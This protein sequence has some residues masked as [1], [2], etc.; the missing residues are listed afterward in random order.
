MSASERPNLT[1]GGMRTGQQSS[2]GPGVP[3]LI[4]I[5]YWCSSGCKAA[6]PG[7]R[8]G[9]TYASAPFRPTNSKP[10]SELPGT[11]AL[12]QLLRVLGADLSSSK[13]PGCDG[14]KDQID[15]ALKGYC[16]ST[17]LFAVVDVLLSIPLNARQKPE[18]SLSQR[19]STSTTRL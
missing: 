15:P 12:Q 14:F 2:A 11:K 18:V 1:S 10:I 19:H 13:K 3:C 6:V 17:L 4:K 8:A 5:I 9:L 7:N 16:R